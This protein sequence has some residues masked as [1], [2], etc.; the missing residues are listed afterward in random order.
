MP[1][2]RI[3]TVLTGEVWKVISINLDLEN[4]GIELLNSHSSDL[5]EGANMS[6]QKDP[7]AHLAFLKSTLIYESFSDQSKMIDL[8]SSEILVIDISNTER[9]QGEEANFFVNIL[10]NPNTKKLGS[11]SVKRLQLEL[12]YRSNKISNR[13]SIL[14]NNCRVI[15]VLDWLVKVKNFLSSNYQRDLTTT[16]NN[17]SRLT[18]KQQLVNYKRPV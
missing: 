3:E 18:N 7:L 11:D 17:N 8:V 10:C 2:T 16:L 12:H 15:A 4:V 6:A 9:K 1:N 13:Y 5:V 14:I